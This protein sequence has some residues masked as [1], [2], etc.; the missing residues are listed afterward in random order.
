MGDTKPGLTYAD[1]GVDIDAGNALGSRD[2]AAGPR[3]DRAPAPMGGLGGFGALFDLK[4]AGFTDPVL[5]AATDGVG[6]KLKIAIDTGCT[7]RRHR[8]RRHVRQ[9]PR[10]PGR[11][12][13]VLPRLF[14]HRRARRRA[15][16]P[17]RRRHRRRLQQAG[18]ALVGGETAEMPG[19]YAAATTTSPASRRRG[20]ARRAAPAPASPGRRDPRPARSGVHC[21]GFS[22]VRRIVG[23]RGLHW[24]ARRP[25]M[26]SETS[27]TRCSRPRSIYVRPLLRAAPRGP[28]E[29]AAHITGGGLPGNFPRVLPAGPARAI[30]CRDGRC[31]RCSAGSPGAAA[32]RMPRCCASSTAGSAWSSC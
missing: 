4:A 10:R 5:V 27:P 23:R 1:A 32:S 19:L 16:A 24:D 3:D 8:P 11:R 2:Q 21:N 9:R 7:T 15:S 14:R 25:S 28:A 6:T 22:L 12:A 13:P 26:P 18:C 20:R 29:G 30:D 17:R 31:R